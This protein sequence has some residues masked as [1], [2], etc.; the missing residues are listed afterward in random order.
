MRSKRWMEIG[1]IV[2]REIRINYMRDEKDFR[3]NEAYKT[4]R[5]NIEFAGDI[6]KSIVLTSCTP[7]EGKSSI[8]LGLAVTL[9]EAGKNVVF[10]DAD[11][12]KS[13]IAGRCGIRGKVKGLTHLLAGRASITEVLF[14]TN[15]SGLHIIFSGLVPPNPSE[16]LGGKRFEQLI[17]F[18]RDHYDYVIVD[19]PPIGSVIDAAVVAKNCDAAVLVVEQGKITGKFIQ[20]TKMQIEKAGCNILGVVL[21]KVDLSNDKYYGKYYGQYYGEQA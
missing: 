1:E 13:V 8:A 3:T 5:T 12:R 9:T 19:A 2:V 10:V 18:L 6:N 7:R 15:I 20:Q 21:N 17:M 14:R 16:L 11:L 4:L